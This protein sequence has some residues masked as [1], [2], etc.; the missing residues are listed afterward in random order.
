M[1]VNVQA[2]TS[3][4]FDIP[5]TVLVAENSAATLSIDTG[6]SIKC[7][8]NIALAITEGTTIVVSAVR[9]HAGVIGT[10]HVPS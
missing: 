4:T 6:D 10:V 7:P 2:G 1:T 9:G 3:Q 5:C 8:T